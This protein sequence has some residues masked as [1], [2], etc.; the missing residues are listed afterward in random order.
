MPMT[1]TQQ[2]SEVHKDIEGL[3]SRDSLSEEELATVDALLA[4]AEQI[5]HQLEAR[6]KMERVDELASK[7]K[8]QS[9]PQPTQD[10]HPKRSKVIDPAQW[11]VGEPNLKKAPYGGFESA[12]NF[13]MA[14]KDKALTG[15]DHRVFT[16]T[17]WETEG[18]DGGYLVPPEISTSIDNKLNSAESLFSLIDTVPI[19]SNSLRRIYDEEQP[20]TGGVQAGWLDEGEAP[21]ETKP[22]YTSEV[23]NLNKLGALIKVSEELLMDAS[24]MG[25]E[26]ARKA[27]DAIM[28]KLNEAIVNG[29]GVGKPTGVLRSPFTIEVAKEQNQVAKTI[30]TKNIIKM[31]TRLLPM[32]RMNAVWLVHAELEEQLLRLKDDNDNYIALSPQWGTQMNV[33][34]YTTLLGKRVIPMMSAMPEAGT[35][36]DIIFADF[37]CFMGVQKGGIQSAQSIHVDFDKG[38]STFRFTFRFGGKVPYKAPVKAQNGNHTRSGIVTLATRG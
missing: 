32:F 23:F 38:L 22:K 10:Q 21:A 14:V 8:R 34:P 7:S 3:R 20:W 35:K 18:Q 37:S 28:H 16:N 9:T 1:L 19:E 11:E 15:R 5:N 12:G 26:I 2:L 4:E 27:P 30:N 33:A 31:Y 13:F 6:E 29:D 36:G 17:A 25:S 24:A